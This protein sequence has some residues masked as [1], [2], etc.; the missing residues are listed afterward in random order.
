MAQAQVN[1]TIAG[2]TYRMACE[3]GQEDHLLGLADQVN[4]HIEHL[5]HEFGDVGDM[6]L[7][8]MAA[9]VLADELHETRRALAETT[10]EARQLTD[11]KAV[12]NDKI[13]SAQIA[14]AEM[15]DSA[16]ARIEALAATVTAPPAD[17]DDA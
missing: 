10:D 15:L 2:R 8:I 12:I 1:V 4:G 16:S 13:I 11:A 17:A 5:R 9:L 14:T 6:R 3:A 7:L